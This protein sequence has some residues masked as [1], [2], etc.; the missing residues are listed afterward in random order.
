MKN[1]AKLDF[2]IATPAIDVSKLQKF[3]WRNAYEKVTAERLARSAAL[4]TNAPKLPPVEAFHYVLS[5]ELAE[6]LIA[7]L[8]RELVAREVPTVIFTRFVAV[9]PSQLIIHKDWGRLT[10]INAYINADSAKTSFYVYAKDTN[11]VQETEAFVASSGE[12]WVMRSKELH[13][14]LFPHAGSREMINFA[15]KRLS[16]EDV[17]EVVCPNLP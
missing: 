3:E 10:V 7:Q 13:G 4:A 15:F 11:T 17:V 1:A 2:S 8:P 6:Q 16:L 12:L 14:V 9:E 5:G